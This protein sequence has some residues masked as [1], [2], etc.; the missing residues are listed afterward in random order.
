VSTKLNR[1]NFYVEPKDYDY[2]QQ[3][4][5][6]RGVSTSALMRILINKFVKFQ[7]G[8]ENATTAE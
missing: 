5:K 3:F 2:L 4:A 6:R 1:R 8:R 7:K